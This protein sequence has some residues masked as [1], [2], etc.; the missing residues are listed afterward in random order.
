MN[1]KNNGFVK[2]YRSIWDNPLSNKPNYLAVWLYLISHAN[3]KDKE[4][5]I[6]NRK[7]KIERGSFLGSQL[8]I[9]NHFN[10]SISS[11]SLI[12]KYL[13]SENQ[14][15]IK[16]TTKFTLFKII[17]YDYYNEGESESE[18]KKKTNRKQKETTKKDKNV[19]KD[20]N[21][22]SVILDFNLFWNLYDKKV[23]DKE[24]VFKKYTRLTLEEREEIKQYIPLYIQSC[25]NKQYRKNPATFLNNKGWKD[26][27]IGEEVNNVLIIS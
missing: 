12:L 14:I 20:K 16:T 7:T 19:K 17:K 26:E 15:E 27:I 23:G 3:F 6:E 8:K 1:N 10:I 21:R 18:N 24:K 5:I 13:I 2:T 25:P 9:A 11:I 22:E 4:I